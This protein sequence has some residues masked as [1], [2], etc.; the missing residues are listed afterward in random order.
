MYNQLLTL[1]L[2]DFQHPLRAESCIHTRV[3][4][5]IFMCRLFLLTFLH[6]QLACKLLNFLFP[7]SW[8]ILSLHSVAWSGMWMWLGWR[9]CRPKRK[10]QQLN[11]RYDTTSYHTISYHPIQ[12]TSIDQIRSDD[13]DT[14]RG[15]KRESEWNHW[16]DL[17]IDEDSSEWES[18]NW[19]SR[20][21]L[22]L[23]TTHRLR[24]HVD[25]TL[26]ISFTDVLSSS[27]PLCWI[28]YWLWFGSWVQYLEGCVE[29]NSAGDWSNRKLT[30]T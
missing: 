4:L 25:T 15:T 10:S 7:L 17:G 20:F 3:A 30:T 9:N 26:D 11:Q 22:A 29:A 6:P 2:F 8:L 23:L 12:H 19:A 16:F 27:S 1:A 28:L 24:H 18:W 21:Q 14:K 13:S 5:C